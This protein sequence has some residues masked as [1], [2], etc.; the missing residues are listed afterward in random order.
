MG[1]LFRE[2]RLTLEGLTDT[3]HVAL[4]SD[5]HVKSK[6]SIACLEE[7]VQGINERDVD[8]V[9]LLGDYIFSPKADFSALGLFS[10]LKPRYGT[11]AVMGNH[12]YALSS[13]LSRSHNEL[14]DSLISVLESS[15]V[16]VLR[17][18]SR[19]LETHAGTLTLVGVESQWYG[20][21]YDK[22]FA[23]AKTE[24]LTFLLTHHP[25]AIRWIPPE[26]R[27]DL[28]VAG[29][30]HG[31]NIR[32]PSG[33]RP[34]FPFIPPWLGGPYD[35]GLKD[36]DGR[37]MYVSSGLGNSPPFPRLFNPPEVVLLELSPPEGGE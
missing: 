14:A 11:Y 12:D 26:R 22:A 23:D 34:M 33:R 37:R 35:R 16:T 21:D 1:V 18:A 15:G 27:T 9:L 3:L 4:L 36:Y 8:L 28:I 29:H 24:N 30:T 17:D 25:H 13:L 10:E 6:R 32:T 19:E 31:Y 7:A 2:E 20:I 5:I